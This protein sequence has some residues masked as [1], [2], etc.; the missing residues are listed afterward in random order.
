[1]R[2]FLAIDIPSAAR[3][4][5]VRL[6]K[7]FR[8]LD[9][10]ASWVP[11]AN[12]HLTL[13]F[14]GETRPGQIP[15]LQERMVK[16]ASE[17][18]RFSVSLC[19]V[20]VFPHWRNPRVLW[21]GMEDPENGLLPLIRRIEDETAAM[22]FPRDARPQVPHL[23]LARIKS[24]KGRGRLRQQAE[25]LEPHLSAPFEVASFQ[26]IESELSRQGAR[27]TTLG[28]FTLTGHSPTHSPATPADPS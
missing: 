12:V 21:V 6:Q 11:P 16:S 24:P 23:T 5:L 13:K 15:E 2:L 25:A 18:P 8:S 22:G 4:N 10:E 7:A 19:G 26:L 3:E 14:L 20:G 17:T 27:Y 1:M 9:L 28:E